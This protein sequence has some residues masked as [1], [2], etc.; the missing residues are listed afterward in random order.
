MLAFSFVIEAKAPVNK[1]KKVD[2]KCFVELVGGGE[3][4]SF[5]NV[6]TSK[7]SRLSKSIAGQKVTVPNS[8][9]K[10]KIY[11]V[12]ECALLKDDFTNSKAKRVDARTAR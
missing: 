3:V 11:K 12:H 8:K 5:W 1:D 10:V 4:V 6:S 7:V 9:Q 2:V